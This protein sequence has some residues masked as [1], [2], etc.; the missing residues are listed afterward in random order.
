[1]PTYHPALFG[2]SAHALANPAGQLLLG[3]DVALQLELALRALTKPLASGG[4]R[5]LGGK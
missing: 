3:F 1:M 2:R 4:E 5:L